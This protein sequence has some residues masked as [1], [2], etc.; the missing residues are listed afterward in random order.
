MAATKAEIAAALGTD[1]A[2]LDTMVGLVNSLQEAGLSQGAIG[3]WAA[4]MGL[5]TGNGKLEGL[6]A[7]IAA[8]DS[9]IGSAR[10]AAVEAI[11]TARARVD[12]A[13]ARVNSGSD[14]E[15]EREAATAAVVT[16]G[17]AVGA[18]A[19]AMGAQAQALAAALGA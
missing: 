7:A 6:S 18:L 8:A 5:A 17:Q 4:T 11:A 15:V 9:A 12:L 14:A 1:E 2:M 10:V 16:A 3:A 19:T 13:R